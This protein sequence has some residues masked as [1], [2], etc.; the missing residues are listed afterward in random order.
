MKKLWS[1]CGVLLLVVAPD[2]EIAA[3]QRAV[4]SR[5]SPAPAAGAPGRDPKKL[6]VLILTGYNMHDWRPITEPLRSML[7]ATDRFE[8]RVN[9]EPVGCNEAP[10]RLR[11]LFPS[12]KRKKETILE[13]NQ[14]NVMKDESRR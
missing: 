5:P 11:P 13:Q 3:L 12:P 14:T 9:E 7:E 8:V 6:Q 10:S 1:I 2:A 4:E